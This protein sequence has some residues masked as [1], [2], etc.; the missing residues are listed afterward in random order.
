[1]IFQLIRIPSLGIVNGLKSASWPANH[2]VYIAAMCNYV[3]GVVTDLKGWHFLFAL[4]LDIV[5]PKAKP[6]AKN[7]P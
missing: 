7:I 5:S 2:L 3:E 1:M 4:N 6:G